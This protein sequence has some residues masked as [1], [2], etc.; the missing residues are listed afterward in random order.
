MFWMSTDGRPSPGKAV[1]PP[2]VTVPNG[3][4]GKSWYWGSDKFTPLLGT[5]TPTLPLLVRLK[6][7]LAVL[8]NDGE[9]MWLSDNVTN[10][11]RLVPWVLAQGNAVP[12]AMVRWLPVAL[13]KDSSSM[14]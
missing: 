14:V 7:A 1:T 2:I 10:W 4:P 6:D 3:C 11:F 9:K 8:S 5:P 13:F 12:V